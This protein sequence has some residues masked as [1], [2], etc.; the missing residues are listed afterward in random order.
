MVVRAKFLFP[1]LFPAFRY[2]MHIVRQWKYPNSQLAQCVW[3]TCGRNSILTSQ[4][5]YAQ[6]VSY[7][8]SCQQL[9]GLCHQ[10]PHD[11]QVQNDIQTPDIKC[12]IIF[13]HRT[14]DPAEMNVDFN[15]IWT[16]QSQRSHIKLRLCFYLN[17]TLR[18]HFSVDFKRI[19][20]LHS[21]FKI[22]ATLQCDLEA[23]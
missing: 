10:M 12:R 15:F 18:V 1:K 5:L 4:F 7:C 14:L 22:F 8:F 19:F 21:F 3:V 2:Y 16:P 9:S 6:R 20:A 13:R 17:V 11:T 23:R